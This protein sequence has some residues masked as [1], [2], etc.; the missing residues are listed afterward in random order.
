[1]PIPMNLP[2]LTTSG[3]A[4]ILYMLLLVIVHLGV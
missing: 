4:M 3:I 1:M 2:S